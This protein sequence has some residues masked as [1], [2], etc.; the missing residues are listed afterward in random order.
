MRSAGDVRNHVSVARATASDLSAGGRG[1]VP[2]DEPGV[3]RGARSTASDLSAGGRG[4]VPADELGVG[5]Q[6]LSARRCQWPSVGEARC[7]LPNQSRTV[8]GA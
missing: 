3:G 6:K 8:P 7:H 5:R 4:A 2:A 1:A